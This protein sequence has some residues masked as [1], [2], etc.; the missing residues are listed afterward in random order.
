M[1]ELLL[2]GSELS[3]ENFA[4]LN[5]RKVKGSSTVRNVWEVHVCQ[6][7]QVLR[8]HVFF[9]INFLSTKFPQT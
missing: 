5:S 1:C 6:N 2:F 3:F 4:L 8:S 7:I 9:L